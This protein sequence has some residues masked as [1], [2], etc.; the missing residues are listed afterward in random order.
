MI[1]IN[2]INR[3]FVRIVEM[4][5][6]SGFKRMNCYY[7]AAGDNLTIIKRHGQ[8]L[9]QMKCKMNTNLNANTNNLL[10]SL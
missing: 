5:W 1:D 6:L 7:F 10:C 4:N 8:M 2:T 9:N 3:S